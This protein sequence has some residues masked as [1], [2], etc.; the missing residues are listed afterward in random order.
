MKEKYNQYKPLFESFI[1]LYLLN[2]LNLLLPLVSIPYLF[3]VVG[4]ANYGVYAFVFVIIQ[5][6]LL[7]SNYGFD[8]SATKQ[9]AQSKD[10]PEK[11]SSIFHAVIVS[12][13]LLAIG[14]ILTL[15]F[16]TYFFFNEIQHRLL[17][18]GLGI[19]LGEIFV[20]VWLFQGLEKMRYLTVTN[21][22]SKILFTA[23]IFVVITKESDF[24]Y[25]ILLNS[26]GSIAAGA[27]SCLIVYKTLNIKFKKPVIGDIV[28]QLKDGLA[29][30][31]STLGMNLYRNSNIFILGLFV[32]DASV[33]V[34]A[35]AEKVIKAIQSIVSPIA[36][37]LF[38]H[39]SSRFKTLDIKEGIQL[40]IRVVKKIAIVLILL[41][42]STYFLSPWIV[43]YIGGKDLIYAVPLIKVFSFVV[44]FGGMNYMLGIVGLINLNRQK[45]FFWNV[46]I[47]GVFSVVFL[48]LTVQL[49]GNM[50][51]VIATVISEV[52]LFTGCSL[53]LYK[54]YNKQEVPI[55]IK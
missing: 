21:T 13:I 27:V 31:G 36:Q 4:A 30:F 11:V 17:W 24:Q 9:I 7:V 3:R 19:V 32:S 2:G 35:A 48:L 38:P 12:R 50:A 39:L 20:P 26:F 41:T 22:V 51:A 34:Y 54:L 15:L 16:L 28:F 42:I 44:F 47:S 46:M 18:L 25:I 14:A 6:V 5:Y 8:F 1:S 37:A 23:L 43:R 52:L 33:G 40:L 45:V 10:D 29:V 49:W 53:G 55:E